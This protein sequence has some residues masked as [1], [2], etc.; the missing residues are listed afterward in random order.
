MSLVPRPPSRLRLVALALAL[1][2]AVPAGA[3]EPRPLSVVASFYPLAEWAAVVGGERIT[4]ENL[5]P[6]G[7]EPHDFEPTPGDLRR[8]RQAD[9]VLTLGAGFQPAVDQALAR[10]AGAQTRVVVTA[11]LRLRQLDDPHAWLDPLLAK[12]IV[13]NIAAA[14]AHADPS[15]QATYEANA[16]AY[17]AKLD[18]LHAKYEQTLATCTRRDL[19]TS[20][21]AFGHLAARYGLEQEAISGISPEAEPTPGRLA[22]LVNLV[23]ARDVRYIFTETLVSPR[24][25]ETL[26]RETG[27]TTL[28]L[29]PIEGLTQAEL[30][31][32]KNYLSVMDE[33]LRNLAIGLECRAP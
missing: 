21:A 25:A 12:E 3:A 30:A 1:A 5:T 14:L 29:N 32:G 6:A 11:G 17:A 2:A 28:V 8:L 22:A 33:N 15:G 31:Q 16:R 24:V 27:A 9:V 7:G 26:A 23:K 4:V 18:A 20:H 13:A 19:I 10:P